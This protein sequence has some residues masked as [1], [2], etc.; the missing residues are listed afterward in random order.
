TVTQL[1]FHPPSDDIR[2][3]HARVALSASDRAYDVLSIDVNGNEEAF[4]AW[5]GG[6]STEWQPN[7]RVDR[8]RKG[9]H[10]AATVAEFVVRCPWIS[11]TLQRIVFH[12]Q[13]HGEGG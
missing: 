7:G 13:E 9:E 1:S 11:G 3:F 8:Y 4:R 12:C 10:P 6:K 2:F 5:A